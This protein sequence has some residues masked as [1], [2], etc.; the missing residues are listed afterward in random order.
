MQRRLVLVCLS[1]LAVAACS[2]DG[3]SSKGSSPVTTT[4]GTTVTGGTVATATTFQPDC[5]T[6]PTAADLSAIVG[7]PLAEGTVTG[8]GTCQFAGLNDQTKV[9]TLS[10]FTDPGDQAT[11]TDLQASLGPSTPLNDPALP[12]AMA[13]PTSVV[14]ISANNAIYVVQS[15]VTGGPAAG[16][17]PSSL[18]VLQRWLAL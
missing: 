4:T 8:S 13:G 10:L 7:V 17:V 12:S 11:F 9:L 14:Y 3:G 6:M 1:L 2:S 5:S 18:A 16:E 15:A